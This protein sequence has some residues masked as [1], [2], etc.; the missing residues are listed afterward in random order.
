[1][2]FLLTSMKTFRTILALISFSALYAHAQ[3]PIAAGYSPAFKVSGGYS[4]ASVAVPSLGR[5]NM[6]G[7][8]VG[9]EAEIKPRVGIGL[10]LSYNRA[11]NAFD[12]GHLADLMTY[13]GG[14]IVYLNKGKKF[15]F[16][17]HGLLGAARETGV[18]FDPNGQILLG[19]V[20]KFAWAAGGGVEYKLDQSLSVRFGADYLNTAFFNPQID[21]KRQGNLRA[22]VDFSFRLGG[23][24]P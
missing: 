17:V 14:P 10:N 23:R 6:Q 22:F 15:D 18:N 20:N 9:L 24:H 3:T 5:V 2:Q 8:E 1:V 7:A 4:Y 11:S 16:Y 12:T 21:F 19:Y 13:M